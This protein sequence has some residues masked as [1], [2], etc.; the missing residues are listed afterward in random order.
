MKKISIIV[1]VYNSKNELDKCLKSICNQTYENLEI[2]CIDDGS[3]D[4]SSQIIDK[5][6]K[7]DTRIKV[8]HKKNGGESSARNTG[9]K[10]ATGEYIAFCDCDDWIEEKMYESLVLTL[11]KNNADLA[12]S[13]WYMDSDSSSKIIK[14][15]FPIYDKSIS[16]DELL[17]YLYM[18][19]HYRGFAYMWNKLYK[20]ELLINKYNNPLFFDETLQLGGDVVF[21]ADIALNVKNASY[22]D[23]PFYHYYQR[24]VSGCHTNDVN[25]LLDWIRAYEIVIQRFKEEQISDEILIYVKRFL[26]YHASNAAEKAIQMKNRTAKKQFQDFMRIYEK[27]YIVTNSQFPERIRR[28]YTILN[29]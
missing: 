13:S 9:L 25:K 11:E 15:K 28:F 26:A 27:E 21:L 6:V 24:S 17:R 18:R 4:G 16:R 5:F 1:P 20:R 2:I 3:T 29:Q 10:I 12:A 19:D 7:K 23:K 22:I 8:I 14:N